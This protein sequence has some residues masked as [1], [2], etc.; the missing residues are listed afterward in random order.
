[1]SSDHNETFVCDLGWSAGSCL[2][3]AIPLSP[4][5][6][7]SPTTFWVWELAVIGVKGDRYVNPRK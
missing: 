5:T 3:I 6:I 7:F 4:L 1:M 2:K